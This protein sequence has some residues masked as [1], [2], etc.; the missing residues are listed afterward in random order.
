MRVASQPELERILNGHPA[1]E[2]GCEAVAEEIATVARD[3]ASVEAHKTGHYLSELRARHALGR[4][5]AHAGAEYSAPIESG[6]GQFGP[7][8]RSITG[9]QGKPFRIQIEGKIIEVRK[10][11]G[12]RGKHIM[13]R[14]AE[15]VAA[16]SPGMR[17]KRRRPWVRIPE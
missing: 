6:T 5:A 13:E 2:A 11:K 1:V 9:A 8:H 15:A 17:F 14:A 4:W 7:T 3:I 10:I 16:R 12:M